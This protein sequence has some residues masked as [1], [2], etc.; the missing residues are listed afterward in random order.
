MNKRIL[1]IFAIAIVVLLGCASNKYL[2]SK[3]KILELEERVSI[4]ITSCK[5]REKDDLQNYHS[6]IMNSG[7]SN[8]CSDELLEFLNKRGYI[9]IDISKN[10]SED[11]AK[12]F[13][14]DLFDENYTVLSTEYMQTKIG[15]INFILE[16]LSNHKQL[17]NIVSLVYVNES[18][19]N[20]RVFY[21]IN[22]DFGYYSKGELIDGTEILKFF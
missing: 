14:K 17:P 13:L 9:E 4:A 16:Y 22:Y 8:L 21:K 10:F 1:L 19:D 20:I 18:N 11:V 7:Y 15:G 6:F 5:I 3:N 2:L 12:I